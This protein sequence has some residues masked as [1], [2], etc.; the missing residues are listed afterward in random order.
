MRDTGHVDRKPGKLLGA[1]GKQGRWGWAPA[2]RPRDMEGGATNPAIAVFAPPPPAPAT[3]ARKPELPT[4]AQDR[5]K[6]PSSPLAKLHKGKV[7]LTPAQ[8]PHPKCGTLKGPQQLAAGGREGSYGPVLRPGLAKPGARL[9]GAE[10]HQGQLDGRG[11][12][13]WQLCSHQV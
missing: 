1:A 9:L 5:A 10:E 3:K 4:L 12:R 2:H 7:C 6:G 11:T 13:K 8:P